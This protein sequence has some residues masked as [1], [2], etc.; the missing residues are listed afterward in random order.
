MLWLVSVLA[1][2]AGALL[3]YG[4]GGGRLA[5]RRAIATPLPALLR[6]GVFALAVAL[7][8]D[9][10]AGVS[11]VPPPWVALDASL[12]MS[13]AGDSAAWRAAIDSARAVDADSIFLF[14]DSLRA[15][16]LPAQPAD[17]HSDVDPVVQRALATGRRVVVV[18]DGELP[19]GT[20]LR[21]LPAGSRVVVVAHARGRDAAAVNL[22][23][24]RAVVAG[25]TTEIRLTVGAGAGGARAGTVHFLLDGRPLGTARFDSLGAF[26]EQD[27]T[28]RT[29][30]AAPEGPAELRA[31]V[32]AAGDAEPRNDTLGVGMDVS[33]E[34]GAV[35]VSTSPDYDARYALAVLRGAL[36]L[37]TRAFYH[38]SPGN[39]RADGSYAPVTEAEVR[40]AFRDAPVAIL[41][42]D[43][44]VFGAPRLATRAP[45]ALIVPSPGDGSEWYV[46]AAPVVAAECRPGGPAV[47]FAPAAARGGRAG[48][49][50]AV[51]GARGAARPRG[52]DPR[53][54]R[55]RRHAAARRGRRRIRPVALG[56]PRR[57]FGR[58]VHRALGKHLRLPGIA[59]RRPT[60]RRFPT[61]AC[62]A[63]AT[64]S[65]GGAARPATATWSWCWSAGTRTPW[66]RCICA[67]RRAPRWRIRRPGRP[68]GTRHA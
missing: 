61:P 14:G 52:R 22:Q 67:F 16:V 41:H 38:L 51:A 46:N 15:A 3:Q 30:I 33:R 10:P 36:A 2:V 43:T 35:F 17:R 26:A 21:Q 44:A 57:R 63:L 1:G 48:T 34:P 23:V 45:L 66:I 28:L 9:A 53:G 68:G 24:P 56:I 13:R 55:R 37:P 11:R 8:L 40:A 50:G 19:Q 25:D 64:R 32:V 39:W 7:L 60:R 47:G 65:R 20:E 5:F 58:R 6:A 62:C 31:V 29:P 42:G 12:S 59:A 54:R 4:W 49:H 18:T 27:V